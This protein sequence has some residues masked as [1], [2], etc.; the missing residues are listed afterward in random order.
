MGADD[1]RKLKDMTGA[2][3]WDKLYP[4]STILREK[5]LNVSLAK[6]QL[7][8]SL[9]DLTK[10]HN[11]RTIETATIQKILNDQSPYDEDTTKKLLDALSNRTTLE[12]G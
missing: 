1:E 8:D 11:L 5:T 2:E 7:A 6:E 10:Y 4:E 12:Q 9:K 3:I